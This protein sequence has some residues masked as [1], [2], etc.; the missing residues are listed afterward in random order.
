MNAGDNDRSKGKCDEPSD[1]SL[2]PPGS[3]YCR[4]DQRD[5]CDY[6]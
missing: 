4:S 1:E 6:K 2:L 5:E 3:D